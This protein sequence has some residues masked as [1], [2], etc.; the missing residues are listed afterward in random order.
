MS[1]VPFSLHSLTLGKENWDSSTGAPLAGDLG[2]GE[3]PDEI[4][5]PQPTLEKGHNSSL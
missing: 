1:L 4:Q 2:V 5:T 3:T